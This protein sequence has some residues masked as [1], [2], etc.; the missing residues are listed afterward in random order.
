MPCIYGKS[1]VATPLAIE[2]GDKEVVGPLVCGMP[3]CVQCQCLWL[4]ASEISRKKSIY[5]EIF[6]CVCCS[7]CLAG[8]NT[9]TAQCFRST[10]ACGHRRKLKR[11][12]W[13][14]WGRSVG[15]DGLLVCVVMHR[16][17]HF[18]SRH[19]TCAFIKQSY[20]VVV[21]M[22]L[23]WLQGFFR[24]SLELKIDQQGV[25]LRQKGR[26]STFLLSTSMVI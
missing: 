7:T 9:P 16:V 26:K 4:S 10:V 21:A 5:M 13:G 20:Q 22:R 18:L 2:L 17:Y 23:L 3:G 15:S 11:W 24:M 1:G 12:S 6:V 14:T 8:Q 25:C 19:C